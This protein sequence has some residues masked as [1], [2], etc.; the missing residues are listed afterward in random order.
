MCGGTFI[1]LR[2]VVDLNQFGWHPL[3]SGRFSRVLSVLF[4]LNQGNWPFL[5]NAPNVSL[6]G[7]RRL[8]SPAHVVPLYPVE[9]AVPDRCL[10]LHIRRLISPVLFSTCS[11]HYLVAFDRRLIRQHYPVALDQS[12]ALSRCLD[13]QNL[14]VTSI[15][16]IRR[17]VVYLDMHNRSLTRR[18]FCKRSPFKV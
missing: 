18:N 10:N 8:R 6:A 7:S 11:S 4:E 1:R 5:R 16:L 2:Y 15:C 9:T 13:W 14:L 17:S 12:T 3:S